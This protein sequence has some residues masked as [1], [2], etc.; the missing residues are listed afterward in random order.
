[1]KPPLLAIALDAADPELIHS[2]TGQGLLPNLKRIIDQGS[3]FSLANHPLYR[4]ENPWVSLLTGC[5]PEKTGYWTPLRFTSAGYRVRDSGAYSFQPC[6]PFYAMVPGRTVTV[7][8]LP[9]CGRLF[10]EADGVQVLGW[11]AHSPMGRGQSR[12]AA[13]FNQLSRRFGAHPAW[14]TQNRGSW[15]DSGRLQ[16]LRSA[17]LEGIQRRS[18]INLALLAEHPADLTLL[19]FSEIHIA[20]HHFWHLN[21]PNHPAFGRNQPPLAD[22]LLEIYRATD[23]ALGELLERRPANANLLVFSPEGGAPNWCDLNSLVFLPELLF[24]WNFPGRSLLASGSMD[25]ELPAVITRPHRNDWLETVWSN[26]YDCLPPNWLPRLFREIFQKA[27]AMPGCN[28]PFY[29]LRRLGELQWQPPVWYQPWW[30]RMK[31]FA[32]PSY[33]DGYIRINLKGREP[34]GIVDPSEYDGV[35]RELCA[36]LSQLRDPR[37]GRPVVDQIVRTREN[38]HNSAPDRRPD[39][40][41]VVLWQRQANDMIEEKTLGRLGPV[42]FWK[43]GSHRSTGFVIGQGPDIPRRTTPGAAQVIDLAPTI[44][45]LLDMAQPGALD[46]KPIFT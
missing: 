13:L 6:K 18:R 36:W 34:Q 7:F 11:G 10:A 31:A 2:W 9:H 25:D 42:P 16:R 3:F 32:L 41:L 12:P 20:G 17:L 38:P 43:S 4:N 15:W 44:L 39:A 29:V 28:F 35:C 24:R 40:D 46:G 45:K 30:P 33:G 22:F 1:M 5:S 37:S 8:D 19:A 21:D 26:Y 27:A 14:R 23:H